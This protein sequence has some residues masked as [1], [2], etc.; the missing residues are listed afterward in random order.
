MA[1][2]TAGEKLL[3]DVNALTILIGSLV[4]M[5][6]NPAQNG[7]EPLLRLFKT[8]L[9][10]IPAAIR[11]CESDMQQSKDAIDDQLKACTEQQAQLNEFSNTLDTRMKELEV[12]ES[13]L[14]R[15]QNS[16]A[17]MRQ[18]LEK[19]TAVVRAREKGCADKESALADRERQCADKEAVLATVV[20]REAEIAEKQRNSK[21]AF[22]RL[23]NVHNTVV[24]LTKRFEDMVGEQ[25][26]AF[27]NLVAQGLDDRLRSLGDSLKEA[28]KT[29][30]ASVT[31][32]VRQTEQKLV[33]EIRSVDEKLFTI[34]N[35]LD[36]GVQRTDLE[37]ISTLVKNINTYA[38]KQSELKKLTDAWEDARETAVGG[39]LSAN[40][41]LD[42]VTVRLGLVA[43]EASVLGVSDDLKTASAAQSAVLEQVSKG[44][45]NLHDAVQAVAKHAASTLRN[46]LLNGLEVL[47]EKVSTAN[48]GLTELV[49]REHGSLFQS[50]EKQ[51]HDLYAVREI[52][53]NKIQ[54]LR[55]EKCQAVS[56]KK[57][58]QRQVASLSSEHLK[59]AGQRDR[60]DT[61]KQQLGQEL[62]AVTNKN[63][64]LHQQVQSLEQENQQ[65]VGQKQETEQQ[66]QTLMMEKATWE[67]QSESLSNK[68]RH[69][70]EALSSVK[71][72]CEGHTGLLIANTDLLHRGEALVREV[73]SLGQD[74]KHKT[75]QL[76]LVTT[77]HANLKLESAAAAAKSMTLQEENKALSR[78]RDE[79]M[80]N[81]ALLQQELAR[82]GSIQARHVL[83]HD[84][85]VKESQAL[86]AERNKL[87][88]Q[89]KEW[90]EEKITERQLGDEIVGLKLALGDAKLAAAKCQGHELLEKLHA[91][92]TMS[93]NQL[94][95]KLSLA[96]DL[97]QQVETRLAA[98]RQTVDELQDNV[99]EYK[100]TVS[101]LNE[102][103]LKAAQELEDVKGQ[104][105]REPVDH[106]TPRKR[107]RLEDQVG[108]VT[109]QDEWDNAVYEAADEL[110][111]LVM[112]FDESSPK[113]VKRTLWT[114]CTMPNVKQERVYWDRFLQE[115]SE[116]LWHCASMVI[117]EGHDYSVITTDNG[118][119][120]CPYHGTNTCL[121]VKVVREAGRPTKTVFTVGKKQ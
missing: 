19:D 69:L 39:V 57:A 35:K 46:E 87:Q 118:Q 1:A 84:A 64:E 14:H 106:Q 5:L 120:T 103:L 59:T 2:E 32:D 9:L 81:V 82:A 90:Q 105:S 72:R 102:Q 33:Q 67:I 63:G 113:L 10:E 47:T 96:T 68:V 115:A 22:E 71:A 76:Q 7:F 108:D 65:L 111:A 121:G 100:K 83:E 98:S 29:H 27:G 51:S 109:A 44:L 112:D 23:K 99:A 25:S 41:K 15:D 50:V 104:M 61:E 54:S 86:E 48:Q 37:S 53:D 88:A 16:L 38:A 42:H 31:E 18:Q 34:E 66:V 91:E 30:L 97:H 74:L 79:L 62:L 77:E 24:T 13:T 95:E 117:S 107:R 101:T 85:L 73:G 28:E 119:A 116:H 114:L 55:L 93:R 17:Q 52:L 58:L 12:K 92:V 89:I 49:Q 21:V 3:C 110:A 43:Q 4:S 75:L 45:G 78:L 56:E 6:A 26:T 60:L 8:R 94:Q 36:Q 20:E 11:T 70:E 40:A 80:A